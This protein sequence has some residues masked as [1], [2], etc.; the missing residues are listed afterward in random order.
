NQLTSPTTT[1]NFSSINDLGS[2]V[3]RQTVAYTKITYPHTADLEGLTKFEKIFV[4]DDLTQPK[5]YFQFSN[6]SGSGAIRFYDLT[7]NK[8][9]DVVDNTTDFECLIPNSGNRKECIAY[10]ESEILTI[11]NLIPVNTS[12]FF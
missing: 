8:K 9:I 12:G 11:T 5:S 1:V 7:N 2:T 4:D 3:G 6:F 10:R